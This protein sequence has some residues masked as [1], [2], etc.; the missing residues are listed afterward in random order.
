MAEDNGNGSPEKM[1]LY[2]EHTLLLTDTLQ[3][4]AVQHGVRPGDIMAA[5]GM[6]STNELHARR[7]VLIPLP[8]SDPKL[9]RARAG[10]LSNRRTRMN[11][12]NTDAIAALRKWY[13]TGSE[14]ELQGRA[15]GGTVEGR[16]TRPH[17]KG[18][19]FDSPLTR[20]AAT[21]RE[22]VSTDSCCGA[23][24]AAAARDDADVDANS[25]EKED[26]NALQEEHGCEKIIEDNEEPLIENVGPAHS[27]P[28]VPP[29]QQ[30][31][32]LVHPSLWSGRRDSNAG[33]LGFEGKSPSSLPS[34][35]E[36]KS[37]IQKLRPKEERHDLE[38]EIEN[39]I[40]AQTRQ[41]Q[42]NGRTKA[43]KKQ[44]RSVQHSGS[45]NASESLGLESLM[46]KEKRSGKSSASLVSE[47][48]LV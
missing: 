6:F 38:G 24:D 15:I 12:R 1:P 7:I 18:S 43:T 31:K 44:R 37:D 20:D 41:S 28:A 5:N 9:V 48:K 33:M 8:G 46:A 39:A 10:S 32:H 40:S 2:R 26:Q 30:P 45:D 3:S 17:R 47:K 4:L 35:S 27:M 19:S 36:A 34:S 21:T 23:G 16:I 29:P 22:R 14:F 25:P 42:Q 13:S 11:T